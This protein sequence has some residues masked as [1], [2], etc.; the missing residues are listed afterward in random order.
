MERWALFLF[1]VL[2]FVIG[3]AWRS[4]RVWRQTGVNPYVLPA[5]DDAQ[6]YAARGFRYVLIG[7]GLYTVLQAAWPQTDDLLGRLAWLNG[8]ALRLAG[9][10]LLLLSFAWM[11]VAQSQMGASWRIGIDTER[12]T[13]LVRH[14]LFRLSRN[15]I[16]LALRASLLG[17]LML[18]PN[19]ATLTLALAGEL[20]MQMQVRQEEAFLRQRHGTGYEEYCAHTRRWL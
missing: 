5:G 8:P 19:A 1:F 20:L 2:Y 15:P 3:F 13:E 18:R 11:C 6:G 16:F 10:S 9:W 12:K 17:L 14:G 4:W 7:L